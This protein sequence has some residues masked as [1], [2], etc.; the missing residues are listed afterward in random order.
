MRRVRKKW[1]QQT[2]E[3]RTT[4]SKRGGRRKGA[5]RKRG[6]KPKVPHRRRRSLDGQTPVHITLRMAPAIARLRRQKQYQA[7][8]QALQRTAF[9]S[10]CTITNWSIQDNHIH[11][12]CEPDDKGA[13]AKSMIAFKTSCARRLNGVVARKGR[14]FA[15]RY[16]CVYLRTPQQVRAALNYV[17]NN[18]RH[19]R[20]DRG[21]PHLRFDPFSSCDSFDGFICDA[22]VRPSHDRPA[23]ARPRFW[24]VRTGWRKHGLIDPRAVPGH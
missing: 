3:F 23:A 9:R 8:R 1:Q 4:E 18:W 12:I 16:H 10:D 13:M 19:H 6:A 17:M 2:I 7:V 11:L 14:V 24:L 21:L 20:A 15:D 5:G 22:P